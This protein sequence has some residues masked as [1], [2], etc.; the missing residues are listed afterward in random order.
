MND[1]CRHIAMR[2]A[3]LLQISAILTTAQSW[4]NSEIVSVCLVI[5]SSL[6]YIW[7]F[8]SRFTHFNPEDGV[9]MLEH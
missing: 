7:Q 3:G 6:L 5:S 4:Y 8:I 1:A 9:R 2:L